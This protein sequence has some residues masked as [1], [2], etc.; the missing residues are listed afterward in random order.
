MEGGG[1]LFQ[2]MSFPSKNYNNQAWEM[3][4]FLTTLR[5]WDCWAGCFNSE[6][7]TGIL[8][9]EKKPQNLHTTIFILNRKFLKILLS[10]EHS[11]SPQK[12]IFSNRRIAQ[13]LL[14]LQWLFHQP[15][16][17]PR[18]TLKPPGQGKSCPR[19]C[20]QLQAEHGNTSPRDCISGWFPV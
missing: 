11:H 7:P 3:R 17:C 5:N 8:T 10:L 20:A 6:T 2:Q 13:A 14:V 12:S 1:F 16:E 9:K 4:V 18:P 19:Q 15:Q